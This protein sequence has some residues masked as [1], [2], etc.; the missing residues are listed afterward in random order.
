MICPGGW[1]NELRTHLPH[2]CFRV[3]INTSTRESFAYP[4]SPFE[5]LPHGRGVLVQLGRIALLFVFSIHFDRDWPNNAF[6]A[7]W[8]LLICIRPLSTRVY[9]IRSFAL[10]AQCFSNRLRFIYSPRVFITAS[11]SSWILLSSYLH[12]PKLSQPKQPN[13]LQLPPVHTRHSCWD[14]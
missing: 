13:Q 1:P 10:I 2:R 14:E 11:N 12:E 4:A 8:S 3:T 7:S 5:R 6:H 9:T